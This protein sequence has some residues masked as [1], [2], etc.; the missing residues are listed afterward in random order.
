VPKTYHV[1]IDALVDDGMLKSMTEGLQQDGE[2]LKARRA[3]KL[4]EGEKNSWLEIELD[5]GKNR[6]IRRMLEALDIE[7]LRLIRVAIGNLVLGSLE[8]GA[9]RALTEAELEGLRLEADI[10]LPA[11]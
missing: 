11:R 2:I 6:H 3:I 1:Q 8:K 9:V 5:E 10:R 7:T 4:R